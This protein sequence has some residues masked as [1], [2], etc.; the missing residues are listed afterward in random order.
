M[1]QYRKDKRDIKTDI[2]EVAD[3]VTYLDDLIKARTSDNQLF[4]VAKVGHSKLSR[5]LDGRDVPDRRVL[6]HYVITPLGMFEPLT[7]SEIMRLEQLYVQ[8]CA[9][10]APKPPTPQDQ[11]KF[12]EQDLERAQSLSAALH[13]RLN[14]AL[15]RGCSSDQHHTTELERI[16][17][18][19]RHRV[20]QMTAEHA[21]LT[22]ELCSVKQEYG[23]A[24]N[25]KHE[26]TSCKQRITELEQQVSEQLQSL[27]QMKRTIDYHN[28]QVRFLRHRVAQLEQRNAQERRLFMQLVVH[29]RSDPYLKG[30]QQ[31]LDDLRYRHAQGE[32]T[33]ARLTKTVTRL[34]EDLTR[35]TGDLERV[36]VERDF[37]RMTASAENATPPLGIPSHFPAPGKEA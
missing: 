33:I 18:E 8:A 3:F 7:D 23:E 11:I 1:P 36:T 29:L 9:V 13:A 15:T 26:L 25:Q 31:E 21:R 5:Y 24:S 14:A 30:L 17:A 4:K 32:D 27:R 16:V 10:Q 20:Q 19:L 2:P 34:T 28:D 35:L 22:A 12:L 6:F 37:L